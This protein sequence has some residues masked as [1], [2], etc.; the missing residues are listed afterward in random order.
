MLLPETGKVANPKSERTPQPGFSSAPRR[1][2][3]PMLFF[4]FFFFFAELGLEL[5]A[6]TFCHSTSLIFVKGFLR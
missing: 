1:I 4:F 2:N 5:G 3:T 6:F